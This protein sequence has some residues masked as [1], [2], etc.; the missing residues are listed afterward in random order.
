[1]ENTTKPLSMG[2]DFSYPQA[3]VGPPFLWY[4]EI[5]AVMVIIIVSLYTDIQSPFGCVKES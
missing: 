1:M 5:V 2:S 4:H 3:D